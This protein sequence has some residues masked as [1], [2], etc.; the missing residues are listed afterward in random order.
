MEAAQ[1]VHKGLEGVYVLESS[2]CLIDTEHGK[3]YYVGYDVEELAE[4]SSYEEVSYLLLNGRLP[5]RSEFEGFLTKLRSEMELTPEEKRDVQYAAKRT[6]PMD[7][8]AAFYLFA[9]KDPPQAKDQM[10][11]AIKAVAKAGSVLGNTIR[12]QRGEEPIES[13]PELGIAGNLIYLV[14]SKRPEQYQVGF[15]DD[16]LIL[17]A[18]HGVPASTFGAVV[19]AS[20]LSDVYS[21]IVT[22]LMTLKGPLHGGAAEAAY[23][24]FVEIGD[25]DR[26]E[27]WLERTLAEKR[28]VMGFGHRVYKIYDPRAKY[29]K[30]MAARAAELAG[31]RVKTLYEI[32]VRLEQAAIE[33][34]SSR[35]LFPN[36]DF[37]TPIVYTAIGIPPGYFTAV[38]AV[39]RV[40]GWVAHVLEYWKDNRLI[41]PLHLYTG[42]EPGQRY[43]PIE[44]RG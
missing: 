34:L 14:T 44:A 6:G 3:L 28:R 42:P 33:K 40:V 11:H 31:G 2:L 21:S 10:E 27:S 9:S 22:G 20:T 35:G 39:S 19:T 7:A 12:V 13:Q 23:Y 15:L 1:R 38:F 32:A 26:V 18:E 29:V 24:Q 30:A 41:R 4:K 25:P 8:L 43:V 5:R 16:I 37:W 17:H 36:V